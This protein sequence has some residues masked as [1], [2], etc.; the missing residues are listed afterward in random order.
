MLSLLNN[1]SY[2][3]AQTIHREKGQ[4]AHCVMTAAQARPLLTHVRDRVQACCVFGMCERGTHRNEERETLK[5]TSTHPSWPSAL[6][7][8]A[9]ARGSRPCHPQETSR[10]RPP[11]QFRHSILRY[12]EPTPADQCVCSDCHTSV[13]ALETTFRSSHLRSS[14]SGNSLDAQ[15]PHWFWRRRCRSDLE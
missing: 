5:A 15:L 4:R 3:S 14:A 12:H 7:R 1:G 10:S 9:A 13:L 2:S 8:C 11:Q 6:D